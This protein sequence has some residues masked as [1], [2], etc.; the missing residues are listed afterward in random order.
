MYNNV[1]SHRG[2][3]GGGG[4]VGEGFVWVSP[5]SIFNCHVWGEHSEES[6]LTGL[7]ATLSMLAS[8]ET[9]LSVNMRRLQRHFVSL[10][11]VSG[12]DSTQD[13]PVNRTGQSTGQES[14]QTG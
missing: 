10:S 8:L 5:A 4:E 13:R 11:N 14:R 6:H 3:G 7:S 2:V 12:Q 1:H 9:T